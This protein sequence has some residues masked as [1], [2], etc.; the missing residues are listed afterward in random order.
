[1]IVVDV[2]VLVY[3]LLLGEHTERARAVLRTGST[4]AAPLLWRY[5]LANVL[6]THI[7]VDEMSSEHASALFGLAERLVHRDL[8]P[9]PIQG[10]LEICAQTGCSAY[11]SHYLYAAQTH[12]TVVV[13]NDQ[14]MLRA[15]PTL[16]TSIEAYLAQR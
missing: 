8:T 1:M 5:E 11:D 12:D 13:T 16:A 9:G 7:R 14:K 15:A 10:V 4:I 3:A 6:A 2:N